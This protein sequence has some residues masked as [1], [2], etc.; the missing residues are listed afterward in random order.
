MP[1]GALR[2]TWVAWAT[3]LLLGCAVVVR[4]PEHPQAN[5]AY[6][7]G[8]RHWLAGDELYGEGGRGFIYL[9]QAAILY[10]PFTFLPRPLEDIAWRLITIGL[11]VAGTW[12]LCRLGQEGRG[13]ELFFPLVTLFVLPKAWA[14]VIHGQA[15]GAMAGLSMLAL[16][17]IHQRRWGRAAALLTFA[18]ACKPL[19]IVFV[20][21]TAALYRPLA[22]RLAVG[23]ALLLAAPFLVKDPGYVTWQYLASIDMLEQAARM[24]QTR[25]WPHLFSLGG[26]A[27]LELTASAR[28]VLRI[29]AALATLAL[30]WLVC[31]REDMRQRELKTENCKMKTENW[32]PGKANRVPRKHARP[33]K[34][35]IPDLKSEIETT[36]SARVLLTIYAIATAYLLLFNP[37]TENN[38]YLI[39]SPVIALIGARAYFVEGRRLRAALLSVGAVFIFA[40]HEVCGHL[41]PRAGM[42]WTSPLV[43]LLFAGDLAR[44]ILLPSAEAPSE[45][46]AARTEPLPARAEER[47]RCRPVRQVTP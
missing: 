18:L 41:T 45:P 8:A 32:P 34:S 26:L 29:A 12:R 3:I 10:V 39:L 14:G 31:C 22:W 2:A 47:D 25:D 20:L 36:P 44:E 33:V 11:F 1:P 40:G 21:L 7:R 37:R 43:C 23:L 27:G 46:L 28:T 35:E 16:G 9:P 38:S 13:I 42:I 4:H 5:R 30:G 15:T 6:A 24:G 19:A 17:E